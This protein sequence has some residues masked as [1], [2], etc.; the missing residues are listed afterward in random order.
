MTFENKVS[1]VMNLFKIRLDM[2]HESYEKWLDMS[3]NSF[4]N[5]A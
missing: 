2:S 3:Y 4:E 1:H 5:R